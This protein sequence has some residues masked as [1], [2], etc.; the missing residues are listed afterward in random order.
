VTFFC[1][2]SRNISKIIH[3]FDGVFVLDVDLATLLRRL[4]QRPEDEFG[5]RQSEREFTARLYPTTDGLP[6]DGIAIDTSRP[7]TQVVDEIIRRTEELD[8]RVSDA[9]QPAR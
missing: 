8:R 2:G 9:P 5:G 4:E 6:E 7:V 1:G 3:L